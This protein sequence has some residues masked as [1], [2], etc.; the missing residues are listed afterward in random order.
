MI[1]S[2]NTRFDVSSNFANT[3]PFAATSTRSASVNAYGLQNNKFAIAGNS[4]GT[5]TTNRFKTF[6]F[7]NS[8]TGSFTTS[9]YGPRKSVM[10]TRTSVFA[11]LNFVASSPYNNGFASAGPTTSFDLIGVQFAAGTATG[12][13]EETVLGWLCINVTR[14]GSGIPDTLN[15]SQWA[16][17]DPNVPP[18]SFGAGHLNPTDQPTAC[19]QPFGQSTTA[20]EP[21]TAAL[22]GLGMLAMGAAGIR[23]MRKRRK[24][25]AASA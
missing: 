7:S 23:R 12:T 6:A 19:G 15:I 20:P 2:L 24:E 4:P 13:G 22:A 8:I 25:S 21:S 5:S 3:D 14:D 11:P 9:A 18:G 1:Q 10:S 16:W 17:Q